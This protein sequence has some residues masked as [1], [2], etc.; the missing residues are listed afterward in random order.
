MVDRQGSSHCADWSGGKVIL[1]GA[2]DVEVKVSLEGWDCFK[3][4][5]E[6][7]CQWVLVVEDQL[8][9]QRNH[10]EVDSGQLVSNEEVL[11]GVGNKPLLELSQ[12]LGESSCNQS[13]IQ[14]LLLLSISLESSLDHGVE[15]VI[16]SIME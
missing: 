6:D 2:V 12:K 1:E 14:L 15:E 8:L 3:E 9:E 4:L 5:V 16:Q 13:I 11:A 7:W 10:L